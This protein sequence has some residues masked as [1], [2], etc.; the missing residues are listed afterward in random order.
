ML[1]ALIFWNNSDAIP[2]EK[3]EKYGKIVHSEI[4]D[5]SEE[6]GS[7]ETKVNGRQLMVI[8]FL[9]KLQFLFFLKKGTQ[10]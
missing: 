6:N 1:M 2:K 3:I 10:G 9:R 7:I 4:V 5:I 8:Q